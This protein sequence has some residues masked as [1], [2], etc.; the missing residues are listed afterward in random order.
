MPALGSQARLLSEDTLARWLLEDSPFRIQLASVLPFYPVDGHELRYANTKLLQPASLIDFG[1]GIADATALPADPNRA[2]S[3]G[4]LAT[5]FR[6][7]YNAQDIFSSSGNDQAAV[8]MAL[9]IRRLLYRYWIS[10]EQGDASTGGDFDGLIKLVDPSKVIDLEGRPLTLEVL[11]HAKELVAS[12]DGRGIVAYTSSVGKRAIHAAHWVRAITPQ[13]AP[14]S[15]PSPAQGRRSEQVLEFD[16]APVYVCDL[17]QR[18]RFDP[19]DPASP[20]TVIGLNDI[21]QGAGVA[22]NIWFFVPGRNNL[23]GITP[24]SL[25]QSMF[26]ARSTI[27]PDGSTVVYHITMPSGVALGNKSSLSVIKNAGIPENR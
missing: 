26:V 27:A 25:S 15:F 7:S 19:N 4:E 22:S 14:M 3:F 24:S 18:L 12:N 21:V 1:A 17:N 9:A 13:Y 11:E 20:A 6:L 8:Q 10:F 23:H 16:G 5:Q 2:F